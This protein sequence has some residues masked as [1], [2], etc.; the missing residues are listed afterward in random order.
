MGEVTA[1]KQ[2]RISD[3][4]PLFQ[5]VRTGRQDK[6]LKQS[7]VLSA[8]SGSPVSV[9]TNSRFRSKGPPVWVFGVGFGEPLLQNGNLSF[10]PDYRANAPRGNTITLPPVTVQRQRVPNPDPHV[11]SAGRL[12]F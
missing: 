8:E 7:C 5:W 3:V 10:R 12:R 6:L 9:E 1:E 4:G 2:Q 11:P